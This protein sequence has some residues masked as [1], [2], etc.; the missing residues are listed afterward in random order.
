MYSRDNGRKLRQRRS[1]VDDGPTV[2]EK[3]DFTN[4]GRYWNA[5]TDVHFFNMNRE[6]FKHERYDDILHTT[7][8]FENTQEGVNP[9]SKGV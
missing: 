3:R 9:K 4:L 1:I 7:Q 6:V 5:D 8:S 2:S